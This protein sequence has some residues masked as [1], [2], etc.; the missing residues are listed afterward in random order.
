MAGLEFQVGKDT[1]AARTMCWRLEQLEH[2]GYGHAAA[3]AIAADVDIDLRLAI[4]LLRRGCP[5]VL[6]ARILL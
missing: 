1:E 5:A 4:D 6:A 3:L 2:A